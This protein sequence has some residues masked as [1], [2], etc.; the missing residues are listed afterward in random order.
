[1]LHTIFPMTDDKLLSYYGHEVIMCILPLEGEAE[2]K[3]RDGK[4]PYVLLG[5][6]LITNTEPY[7][8]ILRDNIGKLAYNFHRLLAACFLYLCWAVALI[9]MAY[10]MPVVAIPFFFTGIFYTVFAVWVALLGYRRE[11]KAKE[12]L[13]T[14]PK[15]TDSLKHIYRG[16]SLYFSRYISKSW[17]EG[18]LWTWTEPLAC[19]A[20]SL[21]ITGLPA[22]YNPWLAFIG[23]PLL[24]TSL[25]FW[26]NEIFQYKNVWNVQEKTISNERHKITNKQL[27]SPAK[28]FPNKAI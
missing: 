24:I 1:M 23:A 17:H 11:E 6:M 26:F 3:K 13:A 12:I 15:L 10:N 20:I 16:D 2:K 9:A 8:V 5:L 7:K 19:F 25:S 27:A 22:L 28:S 21:A 18:K 4:L 14:D